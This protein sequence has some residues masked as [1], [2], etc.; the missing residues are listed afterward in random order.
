ME[1]AAH[2]CRYR[3]RL[4]ALPPGV[5]EQ[6]ILEEDFTEIPTCEICGKERPSRYSRRVTRRER[7]SAQPGEAPLAD[8][9]MVAAASV[10]GSRAL[11]QRLIPARGLIG[12][13]K[14]RGLSAADS[15]RCIDSF[16]KAGWLKASYRFRGTQ[17]ILDKIT[18][19]TPERLSEFAQPGRRARVDEA[20][21]N[22]RLKL[23]PATHPLKDIVTAELND[24]MSPELINALAAIAL[25]ASS[26]ETLSRRV[27]SRRHLSDSKALDR[28]GRQI[29]RLIGNLE[30]FGIRDDAAITLLG[31][32]GA[33]RIGNAVISFPAAGPFVGI[34][35]D[36]LVER[37]A[38]DFPPGGLVSVENLAVFE[39]CARGQV[40][41][42]RDSLIVWSHGWPGRGVHAVVEAT[43]KQRVPIRVWNDLDLKGVGIYRLLHEWA[44]GDANALFMD[45]ESYRRAAF[46]NPL[47]D[48]ARQAIER[49]LLVHPNDPLAGLLRAIVA[50]NAWVE[51]EALLLPDIGYPAR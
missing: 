23:E 3:S 12:E 15:D 4:M 29:E 2:V 49:E 46:R 7:S 17:P 18:V 22:A 5:D 20:L 47:S 13:L 41:A 38:F 39:A 9:H 10:I 43:V 44:G 28:V 32:S 35:R 33:V 8:A 37:T 24:T 31:G 42:T 6:G 25:H 51:Q 27:F 1:D 36:T 26:G 21:A 14:R 40:E 11:V 30:D 16:L 19:S 50:G 48:S 34:S 45:N